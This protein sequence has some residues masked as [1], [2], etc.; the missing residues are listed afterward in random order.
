[1]AETAAAAE[2]VMPST[3]SFPGETFQASVSSIADQA[4]YTPQNVH[5]Q[6]GRQTTVYAVELSLDNSSGKLKQGMPVDVTF[7]N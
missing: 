6:E 1:M 3:D 7:G 5:I 4:E 2:S